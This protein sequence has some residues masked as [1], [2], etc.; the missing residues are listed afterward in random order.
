MSFPLVWVFLSVSASPRFAFISEASQPAPSLPTDNKL[1]PQPR[2]SDTPRLRFRNDRLSA[3]KRRSVPELRECC[4]LGNRSR[5]GGTTESFHPF[6][7][8]S[9]TAFRSN[10]TESS[11]DHLQPGRTPGPDW[12]GLCH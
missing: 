4:R 5:A 12:K 10:C 1:R 9:E 8:E 6:H 3:D 11:P 7:V 2:F